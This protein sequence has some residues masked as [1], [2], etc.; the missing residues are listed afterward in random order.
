MIE[1]RDLVYLREAKENAVKGKDGW[2]VL[3]RKNELGLRKFEEDREQKFGVWKNSRWI[4][5]FLSEK[6][7][8]QKDIWESRRSNVAYVYINQKEISR[9]TTLKTFFQN[10]QPEEI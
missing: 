8:K 1:S 7:K 2:R 4:E 9:E 6:L 5:G 10:S 3:K